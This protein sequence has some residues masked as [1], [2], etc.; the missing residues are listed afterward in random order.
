MSV[1]KSVYI[2]IFSN[3]L[4]PSFF[5]LYS[6]VFRITSLFLNKVA[7]EVF[8][9]PNGMT[10]YLC[11]LCQGW[12]CKMGPFP[13]AWQS[14]SLP[15]SVRVH[16]TGR[17]GWL[18]SDFTRTRDRAVHVPTDTSLSQP[19]KTDFFFITSTECV[20]VRNPTLTTKTDLNPG[21][22]RRNQV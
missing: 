20:W 19:W 3:S 14:S 6:T 22:L 8:F 10:I 4:G 2:W 15:I 1:H 9:R 11:S 18:S 13:L 21:N 5:F 12:F 7:K 17:L 16:G